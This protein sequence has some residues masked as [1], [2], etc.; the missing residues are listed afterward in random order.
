MTAARWHQLVHEF[1]TS[2][3]SLTI[4]Y[5]TCVLMILASTCCLILHLCGANV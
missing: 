2:P 3:L 4:L 1:P 5:V